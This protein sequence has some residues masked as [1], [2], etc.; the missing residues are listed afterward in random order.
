MKHPVLKIKKGAE[1]YDDARPEANRP[2]QH[3]PAAPPAPLKRR[4]RIVL[5]PLV[6]LALVVLLVLRFMPHGPT[7]RATIAGW[8]VVLRATPHDQTL[9]IGVTF[10][11][12]GKGTEHGATPADALI[13]VVAPDTGAELSL[14]GALWKSPMTIRGEMPYTTK[15]KRLHADVTIGGSHVRL[16]LNSRAA[17]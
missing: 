6:F 17:R 10:I 11:E 14:S 13:H 15:L 1:F 7:D 8:E 4:N 3:P 16:T 2:V 12:A 9:I 5:F